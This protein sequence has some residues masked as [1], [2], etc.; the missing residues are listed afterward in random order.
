MGAQAA[1]DDGVDFGEDEGVAVGEAFLG[2]LHPVV[3]VGACRVDAVAELFVVEE[4]GVP[5]E[6]ELVHDDA[7]GEDVVL[8]VVA[9]HVAVVLGGAVGHG[10]AGLVGCVGGGVLW[11]SSGW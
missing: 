9:V 2:S 7:E 4:E 8:G 5:A 6:E 3:L 1:G 10:E 11:R